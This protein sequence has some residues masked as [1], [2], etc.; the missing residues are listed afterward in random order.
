[1]WDRLFKKIVKNQINFLRQK[2]K[3]CLSKLKYCKQK[4]GSGIITK[5]GHQK[6]RSSLHTISKHVATC[7]VWRWGTG[8]RAY[9]SKSAKSTG[10][11]ERVKQVSQVCGCSIL[12]TLQ[13]KKRISEKMQRLTSKLL[14]SL[15]IHTKYE[16]LCSKMGDK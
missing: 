16:D 14:Q 7:L 8:A 15:G 4:N 12:G 2:A 3:L 5:D 13:V 11:A 1:M 9:R 6:L 10:R